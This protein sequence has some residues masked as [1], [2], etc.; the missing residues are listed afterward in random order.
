MPVG[1][2]AAGSSG[3]GAAALSD[4]VADLRSH[5]YME[6]GLSELCAEVAELLAAHNSREEEISYSQADAVL[7]AD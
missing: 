1:A 4:A 7:N 5:I 3:R 2:F 6:E